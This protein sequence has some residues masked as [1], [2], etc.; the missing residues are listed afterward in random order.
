MANNKTSERLARFRSEKAVAHRLKRKRFE[1]LG[2][3]GHGHE[4][5]IE[6]A[7]S[8]D[9][10]WGRLIFA[11]TFDDGNELVAALREEAPD[12]RDIAVYVSDPHVLLA[13][14]P[15]EIFLDPSHTFRLDLATYRSGR[16]QPRGFFVRRLTSE[17]DARAVNRIYAA[18]GMVQVRPDFF[19][20]NRDN[21][22]ITYLVAEDETTG[23]VVGTVTGIDH[24]RAFADPEQGA[25]LWCLAVDPQARHAGIG[26]TLVRRLGE[27]FKAR[28]S[29]FMDLSVLHDNHQA[30]ALYEKLGFRR[31]PAF[32]IKRKNSI[33]ERLFAR[34]LEA[35]DAL[36]PY[37]RLIVDEARRRGVHVEIT[38]AEGG[39][40]RLSSGGRSVHCRESLSEMT[41]GVAM[42]ICDDKAVTRRV[43]ER[44]GLV[45]PEQMT[46]GDDEDELRA[47]L[48]RHGRVVVKPARGEQG[49]AVAVGLS[50]LAEI[51]TAIK[52]AREVCDR[53]LIEACFEGEDLRLVVIDFKLVAAAIRRPPHVIG[54]GRSTIRQLIETLSR[55]R[56]AATGGEST[57]PVDGETQ[58][59]LQLSDLTLDDVL[60]EGRDIV[61]RK[62]ANLHTGGSI[63]D[64]TAI[65]HPRLVEAAIK[66][67]RAIDIPVVGIDF[68][69][70]GPT[71]PDYVF[72]E[73]NERPGLA[74]HEP[75]PTAERF[76]DLLFPLSGHRAALYALGKM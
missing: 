32:S 73:A 76:V 17:A 49:R 15:Q 75:Q 62:A 2:H 54:D 25:S 19:W 74:N 46:A 39:F 65:V 31:I 13:Q 43:V 44:A 18:R 22:A 61:V 3:A 57:I 60:E 71:D 4:E 40:F 36:N 5:A 66:A 59:C 64:V 27:H 68:M 70:K 30:I 7:S 21:R 26:E 9:C 11:Q 23:E 67:A 47:F 48:E 8:I 69:V 53:V 10:G 41:S 38:D 63:H 24:V 45:V 37:A 55:R 42:S 20:S 51:K 72:I 52:A 14:A 58:R 29:A 33:N 16:R 6:P 50:S 1:S 12:H 35:Y 28:G 56:A 34:P